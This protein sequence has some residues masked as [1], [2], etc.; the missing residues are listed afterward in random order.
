MKR[1]PPGAGDVSRR[2]W[3]QIVGATATGLALGCGDNDHPSPEDASAV[4]LEPTPRAF[5]VSVWGNRIGTALVEVRASDE[6][7]TQL[8]LEIGAGGTGAVDVTGLAPD[9]RYEVWILGPG[10]AEFGPYR[11]RTAPDDDDPRSVRIAVSADFDPHP[12]FETELAEHIVAAAPELFVSIGDFPYTDN[13]PPAKTVAAYRRRHAD[14]RTAPAIR[15]L[16][17]ASPVRAI[18]DD[19]EFHNDWDARFA[20]A[21][22]DRYAAA[23]Q[24]WDEFFPIR[25]PAGDIR[26]RSWRWG[27]HVEGFLLDCRRFRGDNSAPDDAAKKMLGDRQRAWIIE[28]VTRSTATFKLVFTSVPLDFGIG[29]DHWAG[30]TTERTLLFDALVG[31]PGVLFVSADQ[32]YFASH[33]H[34]H[35]IREFQVGPLARGLGQPGPEAP[36]VLFRSLQFN[37]GILDVDG[38]SL[39][40]T[41]LGADGTQFFTETLTA[42]ALTPR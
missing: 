3:V 27:K 34:A 29:V 19:H 18:Y 4:I 39:R 15:R 6:V 10:G 38:D 9:R 14:L 25:D 26:Y 23:V 28:A 21:E 36:G 22:P 1:R 11:A 13:G 32:H 17:E 40:I 37:A 24:V 30:Y 5:L 31:T 16:F 33:R 42:D 7:V 2:A 20:A 8:E 12:M 35:G 41:G